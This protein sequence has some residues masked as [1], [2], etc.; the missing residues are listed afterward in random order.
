ML[1]RNRETL[2]RAVE[3]FQETTTEQ[4]LHIGTK[5]F[6]PDFTIRRSD[7]TLFYW[8]HCGMTGSETYMQRHKVKLS[9]YESIGIVPWKNLIV[10]Y[11]D[12]QGC[13]RLSV[14]ESEIR[15]KLL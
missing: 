14:I 4:V 2:H 1:F 12:P 13:V 11:D 10:T 8:E 5:S 15:N 7:G 6:A 9:M 3:T